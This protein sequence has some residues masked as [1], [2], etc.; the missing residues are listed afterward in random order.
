MKIQNLI[1]SVQLC[2]STLETAKFEGGE[3]RE[4]ER[5]RERDRGEGE[6]GGEEEEWRE[7]V[8]FVLP[9]WCV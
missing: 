9:P 5:E 6:E 1:E 7:K 4:R 8:L 2:A 3:R